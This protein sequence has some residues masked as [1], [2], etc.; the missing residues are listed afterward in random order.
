MDVVDKIAQ[1]RTGPGGPFPQDVPRQEVVIQ[2][3]KLLE[4]K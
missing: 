2:S 4:A 1:L 3:V